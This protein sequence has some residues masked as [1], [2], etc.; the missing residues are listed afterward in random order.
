VGTALCAANFFLNNFVSVQSKKN[1]DLNSA[2]NFF[3]YK[4]DKKA[5]RLQNDLANRNIF[6]CSLFRSTNNNNK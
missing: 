4:F 5:V 1:E 2:V 6:V 3:L